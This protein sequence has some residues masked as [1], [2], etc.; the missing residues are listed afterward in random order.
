MCRACR[1]NSPQ[2]SE[3]TPKGRKQRGVNVNCSAL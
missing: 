2:R 3:D 1:C